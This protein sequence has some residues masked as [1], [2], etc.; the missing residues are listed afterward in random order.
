MKPKP[1]LQY[2]EQLYEDQA[3]KGRTLYRFDTE[4]EAKRF[5]AANGDSDSRIYLEDDNN[6]YVTVDSTGE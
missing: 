2:F 5:L 3:A 4:T 6:V 1:F